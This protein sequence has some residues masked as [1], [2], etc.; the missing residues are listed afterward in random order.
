MSELKTTESSS[1][2]LHLR[3]RT[4]LTM[5]GITEVVSFDD[6]SVILKTVC[7]ELTIDGEELHISVLD[8]IKG[9]VSVSGNIISFGYLD[10]QNDGKRARGRFFK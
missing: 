1:H 3:N 8:T 4:D 2:E 7:G 6:C 5:N 9:A 10:R